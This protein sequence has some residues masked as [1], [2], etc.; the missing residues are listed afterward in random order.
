MKTNH[1]NE[2]F[3]L[4]LAALLGVGLLGVQALVNHRAQIR[5]VN[6]E[7]AWLR[8]AEPVRSIFEDFVD[9]QYLADLLVFAMV[10]VESG[11]NASA[12]GSKGERGLMQIMQGTWDEVTE[13]MYRAPLPF[14]KAFDPVINQR[15]GR[16]YLNRLQA[17]LAR[18]RGAWKSDER[19][20]LLACYNGGPS[21]VQEAEF[22]VHQMNSQTRDYVRK[23]S[24]RHNELLQAHAGPTEQYLA[25][26]PEL[27]PT[28]SP[29]DED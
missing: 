28:D 17:F 23:V 12:V 19:S 4:G 22:D 18:H 26:H 27:L 29:S 14:D 16:T 7:E 1:H 5:N 24:Q 11:G 2:H 20:L 6:L 10:D 15:V 13:S 3:L 21:A 25:I 9:R 8:T